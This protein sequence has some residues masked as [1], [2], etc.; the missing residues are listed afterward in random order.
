[1]L[2]ARRDACLVEKHLLEAEIVRVKRKDRLDGN[3]LLEAMLA[4]LPRKPDGC[5]P[6]LS[7]WAEELISVEPV[8]WLEPLLGMVVHVMQVY[9]VNGVL[10]TSLTPQEVR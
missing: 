5:H 3:E 2:D 6:A 10:D 1:M 8:T 9:S 7:D 4:V